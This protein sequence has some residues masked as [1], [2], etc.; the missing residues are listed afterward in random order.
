MS[1]SGFLRFRRCIG[2]TLACRST[3][4]TTGDLLLRRGRAAATSTASLRRVSLLGPESLP[5]CVRRSGSGG[6]FFANNGGWFIGASL[7]VGPSR[8]RLFSAGPL[9]GNCLPSSVEGS[10]CGVVVV[11]A[12]GGAGPLLR[13]APVSV[14]AGCES[15]LGSPR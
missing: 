13:R 14:E 4:S 15:Y 2:P 1:V 11:L 7:I 9:V 12:D 3:R 5:T 10:V 8:L 6:V